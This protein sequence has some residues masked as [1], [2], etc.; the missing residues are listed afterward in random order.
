MSVPITSIKLTRTLGTGADAHVEIGTFALSQGSGSFHVSVVFAASGFSVSKQYILGMSDSIGSSGTDTKALPFVSTGADGSNDFDLIVTRTTTNL[1]LKL[2]RVGG[3]TAASAQIDIRREG[4]AVDTFNASAATGTTSDPSALWENA[5]LTQV[6]GNVGVG[7]SS[8]SGVIHVVR[9]TVN[10]STG[11]PL[12]DIETADTNLVRTGIGLTHRTSGAMA[13]GFGI[14]VAFLL[15]DSAAVLNTAGRIRVVRD[16]ADNS[17]AMQFNTSNSGSDTE[18]MRITPAGRIGIGE[19]SPDNKLHVTDSSITAK[20]ERTTS[21]TNS[22][23][24][25]L[26]LLSTSSGDMTDGFAASLWF[27]IQDNANVENQI[28]Y[29][30]ATRDGADNSGAMT[31]YTINSGTSADAIHMTSSQR[32]GIGTTAPDR[33]LHVMDSDASLSPV[34]ANSRAI[35]EAN[36]SA[37]L[38]FISPS[39]NN[40]GI[41]V[42]DGS[43]AAWMIYAH[44]DDSWRIASAGTEAMRID[45]SQKVGIGVTNPDNILHVSSTDFT[46]LERT[47]TV[48]NNSGA[49]IQLLFNSSNDM[50]D[51]F[52]VGIS[53]AIEDSANV[54][55]AIGFLGY[56]R[57]G[58]DN[59]GRF[60]VNTTNS[61]TSIER[62]TVQPGG[63]TDFGLPSG[64]VTDSPGNVNIAGDIYK[65]G[66]AYTNPDFV[67]EHYYTGKIEKYAKNEGAKDYKGLRPLDEVESFAKEHYR[68]PHMPEGS[69]GM[70]QR[71]DKVLELIEE[72]FLHNIELKREIEALKQSNA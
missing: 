72:L 29:I 67:F 56:R 36:G 61:G 52:G 15:E 49:G 17:G 41:V 11:T 58:A 1:A 14:D 57:L 62:L 4:A 10:T 65:N 18:K 69:M 3:A 6:G 2:R 26:H 71:G 37:Y 39:T 40:A 43:Q 23:V 33:R 19:T 54:S 16:G 53:F 63:R 27:R 7:T 51:E 70:F 12:F 24:S 31:L 25:Q 5:V 13:D 38:E 50:V 66:T 45:S 68:L 30:Q 48:T 35:I 60:F 44:S 22:N 34:N 9:D 28:A 59:S 46:L 8:P 64:S 55:N 21:S 32:V 47:T 42:G 20:I